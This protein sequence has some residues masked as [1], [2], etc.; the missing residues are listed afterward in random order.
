MNYD[1]VLLQEECTKLG[2]LINECKEQ[3]GNKL[4]ADID[5]LV[6]ERVLEILKSQYKVENTGMGYVVS[7]EDEDE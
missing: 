1:A 7:W 6:E 3:G 4:F 5:T 2:K